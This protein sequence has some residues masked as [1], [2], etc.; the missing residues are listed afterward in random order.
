MMC[1]RWVPGFM[2]QGMPGAPGFE[3]SPVLSDVA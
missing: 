1:A 2:I 3:G